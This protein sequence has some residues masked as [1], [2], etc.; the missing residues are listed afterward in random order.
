ML[1][2]LHAIPDLFQ[3]K[4]WT[5]INFMPMFHAAALIGSLCMM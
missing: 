4:Q 3:H 1:Q 5:N 2:S